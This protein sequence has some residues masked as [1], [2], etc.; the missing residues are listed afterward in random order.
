M[1]LSTPMPPCAQTLRILL[2]DDELCIRHILSSTLRLDGHV[3]ETAGDGADALERFG[4]AEWDVVITDR[5]MPRMNGEEL[6]AEIKRQSPQ[7]PVVMITG[8]TSAV[9]AATRECIDALLPKPFSTAA[10]YAALAGA[11]QRKR[12]ERAAVAAPVFPAAA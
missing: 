9:K 7:T 2:V 11:L 3:V 4:Q 1:I 10:L 8:L 5:A 12:P 6:A